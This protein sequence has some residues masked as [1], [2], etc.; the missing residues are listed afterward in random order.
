MPDGTQNVSSATMADV[1]ETLQQ[2][3]GG[4]YRIERELG[5]G[6][7][8]HVF[9]AEDL[10][11]GRE[12]VI[13][14]LAPEMAAGVDADRFER[15]TQL[16]ARLQH[17]YIVPLLAAGVADG[18]PYYTMPFVQGE[19]LRERLERT[20]ELPIR[21]GIKVLRDVA[22]ALAYAHER[23]VVHRDI[24]PAN[25][26]LTQDHA[27]VTDFGIAKAV[28]AATTHAHSSLT[29]AGFAVGTP[30]Y[31][32]PEQALGDPAT[33]HRADIYAFGVLAYE[34]LAGHPPFSQRSDRAVAAAHALEQPRPLDQVRPAVPAELAALVMRCLEKRP[35]D[36]P[37]SA[38]ELVGTLDRL[39]ATNLHTAT[40]RST[41]ARAPR[42][43]RA[44]VFSA[45]LLAAA[46]GA[47]YA[48]H[49]ARRAPAEVRLAVLPFENLGAPTD[50][51]LADGIAEEIGNKLAGVPG[52][53]VIGRRSAAHLKRAG[54]A[55]HDVGKRLDADYVLD[56][57]VRWARA[58][59]GES[60]VRV[61]PQ[62]IRVSNAAQVW[63]EPYEG[64][65]AQVFQ[66][67]TDIAEKVTEAVRLRLLP[68]QRTALRRRP[69]SVAAYDNYL[70]GRYLWK[71]R[72]AALERAAE[73]FEEAIRHDPT[74]A[75]AYSGL[76]DSY[77]LF[78]VNGIT[79]LS[80]D[81]AFA[82]AKAAAVKAVQ[83]DSSLAESWASLGLIL[84]EEDVQ[85]AHDAYRRAI[86]LDPSYATA[87]QWYGEL[88]SH[89]GR[90]EEAIAVGRKAV[91][92]EP[93]TAVAHMVLALPLAALRRYPEAEAE[94][95]RASEIDPTFT[96]VRFLAARIFLEQGKAELART[97]LVR[98][99]I[100][101]AD[102]AAL[103]RR[104]RNAR[105]RER[106]IRAAT[107]GAFTTN[108]Y[109]AVF[110][111][112]V[113]EYDL[114]LD[115]LE[116][117]AQDREAPILALR[118][119]HIFDPLRGHPRFQLVLD[120]IGLSDRELREAGLIAGKNR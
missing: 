36:R 95:R 109:R 105:E 37:Q 68:S 6:G 60:V 38:S 75:P 107:T 7:M 19:S 59:S 16:V 104:P 118:G 117:S 120:G 91:Q 35:A 45:V 81:E 92:L 33:D 1:R 74:F 27:F 93:F 101:P 94:L 82:R 43:T 42:R 32:A 20:G 41:A 54:A 116:R 39:A 64:S 46:S 65:L 80:A 62:L 100:N 66:L 90:Y 76:A 25:I 49:V 70:L 24:K 86:A 51:Y 30:A 34:V 14:V 48:V 2:T 23:G 110:L 17:S 71:Q 3:L 108:F 29:S 99:G 111:T 57:S 31:M 4:S 96:A 119:T 84:L 15:E 9:V 87:Q 102:A 83:L 13:K 5:G 69:T 77:I 112:W 52:L 26:L 18:C 12:V 61:I 115:F 113:G 88:L 98:A 79:S 53:V 58:A 97:S 72:G 63:G 103:T 22:E 67:Q 21:D 106:A 50:E 8:S 89:I 78:R 56:G 28:G 114:A 40:I 73:R 44:A 85:G 11:L 55:P 47:L 10:A